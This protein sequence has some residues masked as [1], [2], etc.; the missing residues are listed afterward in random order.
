MGRGGGGGGGGGECEEVVTLELDEW[1]LCHPTS[2]SPSTSSSSDSPPQQHMNMN[3]NMN[4]NN[5]VVVE[6]NNPIDIEAWLPITESRNGRFWSVIAHLLN[7][8]IGYQA[9]LLPVAFATLGWAWGTI[10][11]C[12]AFVWQLHTTW[13][14]LQLHEPSSSPGIRYS[15]YLRLA[16][17]AFGPKMG[18]LLVIFPVMYLSG[19]SCVMLIINGG[20]SLQLLYN[21]ISGANIHAPILTGAEWFLV[22]TCAA[23]LM[24]QLLP[25]LNSVAKVSVIGAVTGILYCTLIWVLSIRKGRL[26]NVSYDLPAEMDKS[27][28]D[29]F[30]TVLNS[31]GIIVIAFRGHN[32]LLEIQGTLPSSSKHPSKKPMWRGV[33]VSYI[34]VPMCLL[35][36]AIVGFW[37]YGNKVHQNGGMLKAFWE[38]HK[39]ETSNLVMAALYTILIINYLSSYQIYA[40]PAFDTLETIYVLRKKK[41]CSRCVRAGIRIFFGGLTFLIS[42]AFP[43]LGRLSILLAGL[44]LNLTFTYP[45]FIWNCME[46]GGKYGRMWWINLGLGCL[47]IVVSVMLSVAALWNLVHNGIDAN[48]FNP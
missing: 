12:I 30:S 26:Q 28:M 22:F 3:M 36:P 44:T 39:R 31:L 7:S 33:I 29:R 23:I 21:V 43:F 27:V 42:V 15:R 20:G 40:M 19:G 8:G 34:I 25:N 2:Q 17:A 18:K 32:L 38:F 5:M 48:F 47:G 37:A 13:L 35:P 10:T 4:I 1:S 46:K 14:L 9:L 16:I 11:F 24:A 41:R 6:S 45:C